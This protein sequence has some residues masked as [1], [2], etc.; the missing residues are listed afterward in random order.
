MVSTNLTFEYLIKSMIDNKIL[1][2]NNI[3][4][5]NE[6][7]DTKRRTV[8]SYNKISEFKL[9]INEMLNSP[10]LYSPNIK[11]CALSI[12]NAEHNFNLEFNKNLYLQGF[13]ISHHSYNCVYQGVYLQRKESKIDSVDKFIYVLNDL[14]QQICITFNIKYDS[15]K[16]YLMTIE[17]IY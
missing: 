8:T 14:L 11:N 3:L 12:C 10:I 13:N 5:I 4:Q 15:P 1:G 17:I 2:T 6:F 7:V 16:N 9:F